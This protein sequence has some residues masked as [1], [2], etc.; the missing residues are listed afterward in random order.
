MKTGN[1]SC[2][3]FQL[4]V[5]VLFICGLVCAGGCTTPGSSIEVKQTPAHTLSRYKTLAVEITNKDPDFGTNE[6]DQLTGSILGGLRKSGRFDKVY[7]GTTPDEHNAGLKLSVVVQLVL[8]AN[9]NKVQSIEASV[10]LTDLRDGKT[11][12]TALVNA[13]SEWALFGGHMT[14]AIAKLND[15]IVDFATKP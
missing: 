10:A 4:S 3:L 12:A 15:Q 5:F 6:V 13:H 14:N 2:N 1:R 9:M 7:D 8:A 11:L